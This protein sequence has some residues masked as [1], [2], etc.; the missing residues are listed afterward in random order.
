[1]GEASDIAAILR[2]QVERLAR[3]HELAQIDHA[4]AQWGAAT[5]DLRQAV[6][7]FYSARAVVAMYAD[8]AVAAGV[9]LPGEGAYLR[10]RLHTTLDD[11]I[12][13]AK[14]EVRAKREVDSAAG[15]ISR[16]RRDRSRLLAG[17]TALDVTPVMGPYLRFN[18]EL[19]ESETNG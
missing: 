15:V 10:A 12:Q 3:A 14:A 4:S 18:E 17:E 16:K 5:A 19:E 6:D 9:D 7:A 8:D 11:V 13:E 2:T 1:L